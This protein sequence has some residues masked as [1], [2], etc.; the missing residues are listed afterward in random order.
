MS[1]DV[2]AV[3]PSTPRPLAMDVQTAYALHQEGRYAGA[4]RIYHALL[5]RD[6]D[7]AN[8]LHLFGVL[9]QQCGHS[10]RAVELIGRAIK[11]RPEV[12]AFHANLAEAHRALGQHQQ[13][14]A[15][16]TAIC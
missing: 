2:A 13:A 12:A 15:S 3:L 11:R 1:T 4:A 7:D 9:H 6:P 5:E 10:A 16:S 14:A 8:V